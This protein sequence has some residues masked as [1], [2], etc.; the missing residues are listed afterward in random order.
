[1]TRA[2]IWPDPEPDPFIAALIARR[3]EGSKT[4]V[5]YSTPTGERG[6]WVEFR[7]RKPPTSAID[8]SESV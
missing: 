4:V 8:R 2:R 7:F 5:T 3:M 1:M 6:G